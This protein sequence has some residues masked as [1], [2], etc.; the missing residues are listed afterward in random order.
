MRASVLT[1]TRR[2]PPAAESSILAEYERSLAEERAAADTAAE[3]QS[4][5]EAPPPVGWFP[6]DGGGGGGGE[7]SPVACPV[8]RTRR[9]FAH[10]GVLFCACAGLRL[11]LGREGAGTLRWA[12]ARLGEAWGRHARGGCRRAPAAHQQD[13]GG[14]Q[15]GLVAGCDAC[16]W[17]AVVL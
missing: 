13:L 16:G 12:A 11:D 14:G 4:L 7:G 1:A 9:L 8:C 10:R 6:D 5:W 3:A 15:Q 2:P 17:L